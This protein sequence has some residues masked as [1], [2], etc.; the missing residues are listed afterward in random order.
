PAAGVPGFELGP[1][2]I[3]FGLGIHGEKGVAR[4]T[5]RSADDIAAQL[6]DT[7][8]TDLGLVSGDSVALMVNGLGGTSPMELA[9]MVR[10]ALNNPRARGIRVERAWTGNFMTAMEMPGCSLTLLK[11]D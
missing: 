6:L 7:I 2:E 11:M 9:V 5:H 1:D 8:V 3:E 4:S 10:G